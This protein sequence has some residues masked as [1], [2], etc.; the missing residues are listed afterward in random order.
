MNIEYKTNRSL[1][2]NWEANDIYTMECMKDQNYAFQY[3][4]EMF[5]L[6]LAQDFESHKLKYKAKVY[7]ESVSKNVKF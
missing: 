7:L 3:T 2:E 4:F 1:I 5:E 6:Q